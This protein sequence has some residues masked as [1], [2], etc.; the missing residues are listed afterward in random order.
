MLS[1]IVWFK[2]SNDIIQKSFKGLSDLIRPFSWNLEESLSDF[3]MSILHAYALIRPNPMPSHSQSFRK[4]VDII[5]TIYICKEISFVWCFFNVGHRSGY[6]R[7]RFSDYISIY[8]E[9]EIR[10]FAKM[11]KFS[12]EINSY[13]VT[14][15]FHGGHSSHYFVPSLFTGIL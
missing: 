13:L 15:E 7:A 1:V 10:F 8:T 4:Y 6:I 9:T 11:V 2:T 5:E 12:N 3:I 14:I